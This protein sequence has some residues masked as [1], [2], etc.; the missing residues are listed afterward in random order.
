MKKKFKE[1]NKLPLTL[2]Y[3]ENFRDASDKIQN[4]HKINYVTSIE[5][6]TDFLMSI[7]PMKPLV[8]L[9]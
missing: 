6:Q 4:S 1:K 3:I 9:L 8:R 7:K 5:Y 2:K